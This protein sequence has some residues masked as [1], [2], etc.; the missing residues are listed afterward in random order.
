LHHFT[1]FGASFTADLQGKTKL[2]INP[3]SAIGSRI[4]M[5]LKAVQLYKRYLHT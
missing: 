5:A 4:C 1:V 3:L 2:F